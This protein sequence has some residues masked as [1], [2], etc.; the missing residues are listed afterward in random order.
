[1]AAG[2]SKASPPKEAQ[3]KEQTKKLDR[4]TMTLQEKMV[5]IRKAI[6]SITQAAHS[7]GVKYKFAKI[8]DVYRLLAPALNEWGVNFQITSESATRH[9]ENGDEIYYTSYVQRTRN[10]DRVVWLYEADLEVTWTNADQPGD[11]IVVVL[12]AIGTNDSGPDKAKGS[13]WTYCLKYYLFEIFNI[14]QGDEDP[15]NS[16]HSA[17]AI[18]HTPQH[19]G[20]PQ[21]G[22]NTPPQ[23]RNAQNG[24]N[25][26][27][28]RL[29]QSQLNR[30]YRKGEDAGW[31]KETV[32]QRIAQYYGVD[33]PANLTRQQ[34]DD[35]CKQFDDKIQ[36]SGGGQ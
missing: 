21:G 17:E 23:T 11:T 29:T 36:N 7:D 34:Y 24:Q 28:Q 9:A 27:S 14:D 25:Q 12:H 2:T 18:Q 6:P 33:D 20:Q 8:F 26:S 3:P 35:I 30:M 31:T 13:A 5:E 19:A 10:G 4:Y 22:T 1:M 15:D 16:D 32:D